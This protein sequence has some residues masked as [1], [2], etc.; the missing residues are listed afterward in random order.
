MKGKFISPVVIFFLILTLLQLTAGAGTIKDIKKKFYSRNSNLIE[1]ASINGQTAKNILKG[2]SFVPSPLDPSFWKQSPQEFKNSNIKGTWKKEYLKDNKLILKAGSPYSFL[3]WQIA[4]VDITVKFINNKLNQIILNLWNKGDS[5]KTDYKAAKK[6]Y[7]GITEELKYCN[8]KSF[9]EK[10]NISRV[11]KRKWETYDIEGTYL[12]LSFERDE[13]FIVKLRHKGVRPLEGT[14][15]NRY[16]KKRL[17]KDFLLSLKQNVKRK[18]NG[19]VYISG[20]PMIEQGEKGY[21]APATC[22]RVMCYY[23]IDVD[24]H[25]LADTMK[26]D[27]GRGTLQSQ[28]EHTLRWLCRGNPI[29]YKHIVFF[30]PRIIKKYI[31][32]GIPIIW[33]IPGHLRLII[34]Y[35]ESTEEILY[36]DSWGLWAKFRRMTYKKAKRIS[37]GLYVLR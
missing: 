3:I 36:S 12:S 10:Q 27:I 4:P 29:I 37:V 24:M 5:D 31:N 35:N 26:T 18:E 21:C 33:E 11:V 23:G 19:D 6:I 17:R 8:I 34:G 30:K 9:T 16:K 25:L 32:K 22:A 28:T 7:K 15:Q 20:I 13:Y 14:I 1:S 2:I